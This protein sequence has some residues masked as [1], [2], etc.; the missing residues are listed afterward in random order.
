MPKH[1][2]DGPLDVKAAKAKAAAI[3]ADPKSHG[4][5]ADHEK[6]QR[7]ERLDDPGYQQPPD[8]GPEV[9][10]EWVHADEG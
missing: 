6:S 1:P 4:Q 10:D 7:A 5:S 9:G 2:E 8:V 3:L